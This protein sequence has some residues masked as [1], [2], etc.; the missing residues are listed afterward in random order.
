M[1]NPS[2]CKTGKGGT[3]GVGALGDDDGELTL[4]GVE[5]VKVFRLL[6]VVRTGMR[7]RLPK[8]ENL[9]K[10]H[11]MNNDFFDLDVSVAWVQTER[12]LE[13]QAF[14]TVIQISKA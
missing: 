7:L 4:A 9:S 3:V 2:D 1:T 10:R 11:R 13:K 6:R 12:S 14:L 8:N 5:V